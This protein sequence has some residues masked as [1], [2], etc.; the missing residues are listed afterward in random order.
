MPI[1]AAVA[2]AARLL[3]RETG[4]PAFAVRCDRLVHVVAPFQPG[5]KLVGELS[6]L[7]QP[8]RKARV[9]DAFCAAQG[10][11]AR[12]RQHRILRKSRGLLSL[13]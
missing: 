1:S 10:N 5:A 3:A 6:R 9:R 8:R 4:F 13:F 2:A 12:R 7:T 11:R